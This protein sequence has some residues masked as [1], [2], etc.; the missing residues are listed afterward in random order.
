MIVWYPLLKLVV[1]ALLL[2]LAVRPIQKHISAYKERERQAFQ[3]G[4]EMFRDDTYLPREGKKYV[5]LVIV[6]LLIFMTPFRL[7]SPQSLEQKVLMYDV[8]ISA[9]VEI[10]RKARSEYQPGNNEETIK[11]I[12]NK[13]SKQ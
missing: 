4:T 1:M 6:L 7:Q 11:R 2:W 12:L 13:D 10:E 5:P 3:D 8:P 9:P